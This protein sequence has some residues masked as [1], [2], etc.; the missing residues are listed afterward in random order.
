MTGKDPDERGIEGVGDMRGKGA[1]KAR[2]TERNKGRQG[3]RQTNTERQRDRKAERQTATQGQT[4]TETKTERQ[5][6]RRPSHELR[7]DSAATPMHEKSELEVN[8]IVGSGR[9]LLLGIC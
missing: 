4:E 9:G 1:K 7:M 6:A 8:W 2:E 5:K 3:N